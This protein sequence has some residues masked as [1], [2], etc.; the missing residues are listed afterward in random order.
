VIL[1]RE[2]ELRVAGRKQAK[3]VVRFG[4][5]RRFPRSDF[6]CRFGIDGLSKPIAMTIFGVDGIQALDLAMK[7]ALVRL[8]LS[9]EYQA[10]RL[11][12]LGSYDLG[13]PVTD[14]IADRL[15]PDPRPRRR[16]TR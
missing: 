14:A 2:L 13:L 3:V 8:V 4:K 11:T 5:P 16:P 12:F 7:T 15:R 10:G 1:E 6:G 9:D